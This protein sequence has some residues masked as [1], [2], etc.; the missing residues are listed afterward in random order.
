MAGLSLGLHFTVPFS[1]MGC[2][3]VN[4]MIYAC[5]LCHFLFERKSEPEQCPDCGKY[6]IRPATEEERQEFTQRMR[7]SKKD[8]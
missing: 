6:A 2:G 5:D 3:R 4:D 1:I 7:E 8:W